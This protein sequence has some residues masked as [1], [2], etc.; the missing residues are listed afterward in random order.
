MRNVC[1]IAAVVLAGS[2]SAVQAADIT[3]VLVD[4]A[5]YLQDK[6]NTTNAHKGMGETCVQACAKKGGT[7][8]LVT[9][10]EAVRRH[11]DGQP[12]W[13]EQCQARASYVS[14][15][16]VD[17]RH[18]RVAGQEDENTSCHRA[19]DDFEVTFCHRAMTAYEKRPSWP[20]E[21]TRVAPSRP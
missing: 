2:V 21:E 14:H 10:R 8:A 20:I 7:V 5:C 19:E 12:G 3:G 9:E 15:S 6:A 4:K 13:R 16:D 17:R 1:L 18:R 11:D